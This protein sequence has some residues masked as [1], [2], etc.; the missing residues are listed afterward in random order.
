MSH[1]RFQ[2]HKRWRDAEPEVEGDWAPVERE[3]E[4]DPT[5]L[6]QQGVEIPVEVSGESAFVKRGADAVADN[7]ERARFRLGAEGKRGQ[8]H[9]I[10]DV[11]EPH[12]SEDEGQAGAQEGSET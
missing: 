3:V 11:L 1:E 2:A 10:K 4:D 12:P 6:E 5:L 7:E 8:K 9:D